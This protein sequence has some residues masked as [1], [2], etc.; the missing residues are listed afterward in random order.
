MV[1]LGWVDLRPLIA[2]KPCNPGLFVFHHELK[3]H[4]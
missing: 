1:N 3:P 4:L 2:Q